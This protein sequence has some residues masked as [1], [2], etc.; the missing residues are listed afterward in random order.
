MTFNSWIYFKRY[1]TFDI[2]KRKMAVEDFESGKGKMYG[3]G[4]IDVTTG[5]YERS[6]RF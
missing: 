2:E 3:N 1:A 5:F 6:G 4:A